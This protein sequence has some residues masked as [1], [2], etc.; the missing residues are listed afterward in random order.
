LAFFEVGGGG[1]FA[2]RFMASSKLIPGNLRSMA[3]GMRERYHKPKIFSNL[4]C[5]TPWR[6]GVLSP[7]VFFS[8]GFW[9]CL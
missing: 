6:Y 1:V 7:S 2:S 9:S 4:F 3:F 8:T 5:G